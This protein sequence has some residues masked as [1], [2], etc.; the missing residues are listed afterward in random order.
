M[1]S[2][3]DPIM[4]ILTNSSR[5]ACVKIKARV[6]LK[7]VDAEYWLESLDYNNHRK[8]KNKMILEMKFKV[9]G[10]FGWNSENLVVLTP[11][12]PCGFT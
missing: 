12:Q 11:H 6:S 5:L 10:K 8:Q 3:W 1:A 9:Y 2:H 4:Q 7:K